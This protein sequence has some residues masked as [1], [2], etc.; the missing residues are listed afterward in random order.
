MSGRLIRYSVFDIFLNL[1]LPRIFT[2]CRVTRLVLE[3]SI[4]L[5]ETLRLVP[6]P[7]ELAV[8]RWALATSPHR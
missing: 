3:C 5:V 8:D 7:V 1:F 4:G 6:S 2:L